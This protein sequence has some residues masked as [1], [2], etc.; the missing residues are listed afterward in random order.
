MQPN[1]RH[2]GGEQALELGEGV[3]GEWEFG[4]RLQPASAVLLSREAHSDDGAAQAIPYFVRLQ[5]FTEQVEGGEPHRGVLC[6]VLAQARVAAVVL[7]VDGGRKCLDGEG[8]I[9]WVR[10]QG[11]REGLSGEV[12]AEVGFGRGRFSGDAHFGGGRMLDQIEVKNFAELI[13]ERRLGQLV[14]VGGDNSTRV[15]GVSVRELNLRL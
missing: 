4:R 5:F 2:R 14:R 15:P 7:E 8:G 3:L 1:R 10:E 13:G 6:A 12:Q 9:G 11:Q